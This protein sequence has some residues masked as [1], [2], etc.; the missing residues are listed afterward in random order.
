MLSYFGPLPP[1][2]ADVLPRSDTWGDPHASSQPGSK[3]ATPTKTGQT[4]AALDSK[5]VKEVPSP[6][7]SNGHSRS[8]HAHDAE[9]NGGMPTIAGYMGSPPPP[10]GAFSTPTG[11]RGLDDDDYNSRAPAALPPYSAPI[12]YHADGRPGDAG[13]ATTMY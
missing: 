1:A 3:P 9:A 12:T 6:E 5:L 11:G 8:Q 7:H 13:S 10:P 4:G 2:G